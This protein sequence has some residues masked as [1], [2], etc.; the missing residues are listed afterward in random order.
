MTSCVFEMD[1]ITE[2]VTL[3]LFVK[4]PTTKAPKVLVLSPS[5]TWCPLLFSSS[6]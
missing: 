1:P 3:L 6:V 4:L 5:N 2:S